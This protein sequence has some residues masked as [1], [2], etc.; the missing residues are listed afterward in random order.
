METGNSTAGNSYK[1]DW[2][3]IAKLF[4][5]ETSVNWKHVKTKR[6]C[7]K[8]TRNG[9]NT[10]IEQHLK[11]IMLAQICSKN[12]HKRTVEEKNEKTIPYFRVVGQ[13]LLTY[14]IIEIKDGFYI[15]DQHAANERINYEKFTK[16]LNSKIE[17]CTDRKSVV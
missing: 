1:Q 10:R 7:Q 4:I 8:E 16:L 12:R 5:V 13:V 2:E 9:A 6:C 14:I 15:V 3:H 11:G 17:V